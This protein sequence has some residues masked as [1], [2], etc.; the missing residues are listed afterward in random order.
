MT[1]LMDTLNALLELESSMKNFYEGA[2]GRIK[3][4][5]LAQDV[6]KIRDQE[7][8]HVTLVREMLRIV[9]TSNA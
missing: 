4:E 9:E 7:I 6:T 5:R 3:N 2:L 1:E 8:G